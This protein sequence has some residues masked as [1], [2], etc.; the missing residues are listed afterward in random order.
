MRYTTPPRR[1]Q[2]LQLRIQQ[3]YDAFLILD[4]EATCFQGTDFDYPNEIIV[5]SVSFT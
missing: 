3:P 5:R 2:S 4:V 1:P